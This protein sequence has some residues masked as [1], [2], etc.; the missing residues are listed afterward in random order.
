MA[1]PGKKRRARGRIRMPAR[2]TRAESRRRYLNRFPSIRA[3]L[4]RRAKRVVPARA[5]TIADRALQARWWKN[6]GRYDMQG[7][8]T[9]GSAPSTLIPSPSKRRARSRPQRAASRITTAPG[10]ADPRRSYRFRWRLVDLVDLDDLVTSHK[11]TFEPDQRF[12]SEPQPRLR[13]RAGARLKVGKIARTLSPDALLLDTHQID[14]GPMIVAPDLVVESWNGRTMALRM[15]L[16][17]FPKRWREY[18]GELRK[19]LEEYGLRSGDL[20]GIEA[21]VLVRERISDVDRIA[22]AREANQSAVLQLSPLELALQDAKVLSDRVIRTLQVRD[23]Q[24]L[25]Q[26]LTSPANRGLVRHF[27]GK[28]PENERAALIDGSEDLNLQGIRGRGGTEAHPDLLRVHR[29]AGQ[30][31]GGGC[32][33]GSVPSGPG[34][35][36]RRWIRRVLTLGLWR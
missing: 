30:E 19:R 18:V 24:S 28:V 29:P 9:P 31:R 34:H 7:I 5:K 11:D 13:D 35:Q 1:A 23:A 4:A 16:R 12:P 26:A 10:I 36:L 2:P 8:D 33:C 15:A 17:E 27:L 6:P 25:D 3:D 14:Q 20:R 32:W 21:P 22:F